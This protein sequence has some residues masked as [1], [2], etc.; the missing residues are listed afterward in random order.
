VT[1]Q[2]DSI[3][4][5]AVKANVF[6]IGLVFQCSR[7]KRHNWYAV[8][9]FD[10]RFNCKS[11]FAHEV[12]PRLDATKWCYTSDGFFRTSNKLDGNI[13]ILLAL[14]F[15]SN[16]FDRSLQF[17]PSFDYSLDGEPH[18]MDFA[19][20]SSGGILSR[21]VDMI[22]GESKSGAALKEDE[23]KK[24]RI[25]GERTGSYMCFCT[26]SDDF[27]E[28]DKAFFRDLVDAKIKII[29]LT[30]FLLEMDYF[31]RMK[32]STENDPGRSRTKTDWMMRATILRTLGKEFA[33]KHNI[34]L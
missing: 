18:E 24:L 27:D 8:T 12:T 16:S 32:Y 3:L 31:E 4:D 7:C 5:R 14:N 2:V 20:I 34:W 33:L 13:T 11:C 28:A 17:A 6:R 1:Q 21:E 23:R 26:L 19:V 10:D 9:E 15:F 29:M 30:R 25:F 22:F